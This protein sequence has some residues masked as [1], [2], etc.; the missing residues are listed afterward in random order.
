MISTS[1]SAVRRALGLTSAVQEALLSGHIGQRQLHTFPV[2]S[3]SA[4]G[5]LRKKTGYSLSL[6][7]KALAENDQDVGKA[8]AWL[9]EKAQAEG[10]NK[11]N[12][13]EGRNTTQGLIGLQA[14]KC[15]TAAAMVELNSET[16]FVARNKS[17]H[18]LLN[19]IVEVCLA[20][21]Q[22][23]SSDAQVSVEHM[24]KSALGEVQTPEG[25]TLA[26]L[27]ALN[28]GQ[29]G[30]N[31]ILKRAVL[32]KTGQCQSNQETKLCA[33]THPFTAASVADVAYGRFGS[34]LAYSADKT[35]KKVMPEGQTIES[36]TKQVCQ[37][38]IGMNPAS[39]GDPNKEPEIV[40]KEA[41][42]TIV[43]EPRG[44]GEMADEDWSQ[45][46]DSQLSVNTSELVHQPFLANTAL[47]VKDVLMEAGLE[48][49]DF[50]RFEVGE[51]VKE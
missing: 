22:S 9:D 39:V 2:L 27:V 21:A 29:I 11:A 42:K 4:L 15:G 6:C 30:E 43:E 36:L 23:L 24:N 12:K 19:S 32:F 20:R 51:E 37:H 50:A 10:W 16:D 17:F 18:I 41:K 13:L 47:A 25:K 33:L 40:A 35:N 26:D 14:T 28:I 5:Q 44:E 8:K 1:R 49:K 3:V 31:L 38:V 7:K 48:V 34:V 46:E 45:Y